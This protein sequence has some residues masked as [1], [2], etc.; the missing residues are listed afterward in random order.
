MLGPPRD[1]IDLGERVNTFWSIV[2]LDK[3]AALTL[4]F[5]NTINNNVS[6]SSLHL[7]ASR[8]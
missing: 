1:A 4:G 8:D 6:K 3:M 5:P 7:T 2:A